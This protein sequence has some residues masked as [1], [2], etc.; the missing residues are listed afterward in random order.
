MKQNLKRILILTGDAG[1]GHRSA[2][3]A[4]RAAIQNEYGESCKVE[5]SNPFDQSDIPDLIR[6]SQSN[7]DEIVK[8][9][10]E[11]YEFAYEISDG[12]LQASLM[13]GG[14][15]LLLFRVLKDILNEFE[16]DLVI[17][18]YPIYPAPLDTVSEL[19]KLTFP[20]MI[21]VTDF[22]TVH[23]IWFNKN[24][25]ICTVP[26][27]AVKEIALN[28]GLKSEQIINIGIPV[29]PKISVLKERNKEE[30]R[31]ELGWDQNR[32]T[33]LVVGSPRINSLME[34]IRVMDKSDHDI[35]FALVAGGN[36]DLYQTYI[37]AKLKHPAKVY[38]FV[39]NLPEMMRASDLI[40]CKAG[41]LIVTESLA[42]G[43]PMMLIHMLPGQE[44]GNVD[45]VMENEA[46]MFCETP[47][48]ARKVLD[49]WL[50]DGGKKLK[51]I[52]KNAEEFG[53]PQAAQ[54]IAKKAW[55]LIH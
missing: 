13:E 3:E 6:Q 55:E 43:L 23:H 35:Q 38:N 22:I 46:G 20:W 42:S 1:L 10:P 18:T 21:V 2:A 17:T 52:G 34:Y 5:I 24:A 12:N 25:T 48:E 15:T 54:Q 49:Q 33:L 30:L 41:G 9:M 31:K 40:I 51:E 53:R 27:E 26:T 4:I 8:Q 19:E 28:A 32:T 14:F 7:Y 45:Y 47:Q 44:E 37:N 29:D 36:D 16:P 50:S 39:E 11:L